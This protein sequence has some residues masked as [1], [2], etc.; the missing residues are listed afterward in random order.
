MTGTAASTDPSTV[1]G[2]M[3]AL[4]T[5]SSHSTFASSS[6]TS[7][8][9]SLGSPPTEKLTRTNFLLW[10]AINLPQIKGAQMAHFLDAASPA[11][12]ATLTITNDGKEEQVVNYARTIW[13]AQ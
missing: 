10:K 5:Q 8:D 6:S 12:P 1:A 9:T 4:V 7:S 13:Y 11:L 3:G 2:T